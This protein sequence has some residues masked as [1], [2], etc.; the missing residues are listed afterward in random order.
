MNSERDAESSNV[1]VQTL[2]SFLTI[3][4]KAAN[5]SLCN[6]EECTIPRSELFQKELAG[7]IIDEYTKSALH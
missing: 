4:R 5:V 3:E 6:T 1:L 7:C 2:A